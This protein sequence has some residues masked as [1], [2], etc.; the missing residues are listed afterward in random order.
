MPVSQISSSAPQAAYSP[1]TVEAGAKAGAVVDL[2]AQKYQVQAQRE[3]VRDAALFFEECYGKLIAAE[4]RLATYANQ[5]DPTPAGLQKI[6]AEVAELSAFVEEVHHAIG[7]AMN[8][9]ATAANP[10]GLAGKGMSVAWGSGADYRRIVNNGESWWMYGQ[11]LTFRGDSQLPVKPNAESIELHRSLLDK[12]QGELAAVEKTLA[13]DSGS[14]RIGAESMQQYA[15]WLKAEMGQTQVSLQKAEE[16]LRPWKALGLTAG[17]E[18]TLPVQPN[19]ESLRAHKE[20]MAVYRQELA[21]ADQ[22]LE[23]MDKGWVSSLTPGEVRD[24]RNWLQAEIDRTHA[25][26]L[27]AQEVVGKRIGAKRDRDQH[28]HD[29]MKAH[30]GSLC[31]DLGKI[32]D[33]AVHASQAEVDA[34]ERQIA[35]LEDSM[36]KLKASMELADAVMNGRYIPAH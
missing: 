1:S 8:A 30:Y 16:T 23:G 14:T 22:A 17:A 35:D 31:M 36:G 29:Q 3:A 28:V 20:R 5:K 18:S 34:L 10:E 15:D 24:R 4:I 33:K 27:S 13:S 12:Y 32:H 11:P 7:A 21:A 9:I 6:K 25:S 19:L 2:V 26:L